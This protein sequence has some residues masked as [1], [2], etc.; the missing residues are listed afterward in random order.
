[1]PA[2]RFCFIA[3]LMG[4]F[5]A[6]PSPIFAYA[7]VS[8][9]QPDASWCDA[10]SAI[11]CV[12]NADTG[13][14]FIEPRYCDDRATLAGLVNAESGAQPYRVQVAVAQIFLRYAERNESTICW[15]ARFTGFSSVPA[16]VRRNPAS[17][18]A[19]RFF[20]PP[21]ELLD[22]AGQVLRHEL[23]DETGGMTN[24]DGSSD[25]MSI[26]FSN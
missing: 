22:M 7:P 17:Y 10:R 23:A 19:S 3:L 26:I 8:D 16:Y 5:T 20:S 14:S 11:Q 1:M 4:L 18:Q 15:M 6:T 13:A 9:T 24:F 12:V 25:G 21:P 2:A